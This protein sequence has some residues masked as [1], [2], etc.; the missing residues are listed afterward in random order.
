MQHRDHQHQLRYAS[1]PYLFSARVAWMGIRS[2]QNSAAAAVVLTAAVPAPVHPTDTPG[3]TG[4]GAVT[5]PGGEQ[6]PE[7]APR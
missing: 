7:E 4:G 3:G 5:Y 2:G 1:G 6:P